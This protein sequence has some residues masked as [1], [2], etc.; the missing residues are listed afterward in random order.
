MS[1]DKKFV[2]DG[3]VVAD[4]NFEGAPWYRKPRKGSESIE[5]PDLQLTK[6]ETIQILKTAM[7]AGL[8]IALIYVVAFFAF[9][10]FS[11]QVWLK[12]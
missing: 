10:L 3:F 2:D 7:L 1:D 11:T 5:T 6:K 9:I 12:P 8:L 4:M